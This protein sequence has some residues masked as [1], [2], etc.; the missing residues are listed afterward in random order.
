[1][2]GH[3]EKTSS[4]LS[5]VNIADQ[6]QWNLD[7]SAKRQKFE[8]IIETLLGM[9]PMAELSRFAFFRER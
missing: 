1:R 7:P 9:Q 6:R 2:R 5:V 8:S 4:A 3:R